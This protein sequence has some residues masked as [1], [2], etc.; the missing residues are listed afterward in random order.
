MIDARN[1]FTQID[2]AHREFSGEQ[3]ANIAVISH[4]RKGNR[5]RFTELVDGYFAAGWEQ[6]QA[7][8]KR[9]EPV[10]N[11]VLEFLDGDDEDEPASQSTGEVEDLRP[12]AER[13]VAE[14]LKTWKGLKKHRQRYDK[15][16]AAH[17][18]ATTVAKQNKAQRSLRE[19]I[20]PFFA[21]LHE[22]LK[23][24]EKMAEEIY[25]E[26]FVR[27][28]FPGY[29]DTKF[30]KGVP[31][32]WGMKP[33]FEV[34]K[35]MRVGVSKRDLSNDELYVGLE[36]LPRRSFA[37]RDYT[38]A[39][40]VDSNKFRFSEGD[41]LFGKIRPYLHKVVLSHVSGACTTDAIVLRP[42]LPI[43]RGFLLLTVF[44]DSFVE[45]A[46][47]ASKGTKMPR[48]DWAFL[49]SL[50][51]KVPPVPLLKQFDV[52]FNGFYAQIVKLLRKNEILHKS[53]DLLL[54]RLISGRLSCRASRHPI[55]AEH[56]GRSGRGISRRR[57]SLNSRQPGP[58][59]RRFA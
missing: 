20:D 15:Y 40:S 5:E 19:S 6:F 47:I 46:T 29:Q 56:A 30:V 25:R 53:R 7:T 2:R 13:A 37:L 33:I 3:I 22:G 32:G 18:D 8:D 54:G 16:L 4:L 27:M 55:P 50:E 39:A 51:I 38:T 14:M 31:E 12:D 43:L 10:A 35:E 52:C 57:P 28:R 58:T 1:I 41:I 23:R 9:V 48:A 42:K 49:Q 36:H 11:Q 17:A 21:A 59:A 24:L 45:L 34:S 44:S 26:W